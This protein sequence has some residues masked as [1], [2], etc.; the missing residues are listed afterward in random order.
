M[1]NFNKSNISLR[2]II[3]SLN[4]DRVYDFLIPFRSLVFYG[5]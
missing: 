1:I 4:R 2:Q 3:I 5:L